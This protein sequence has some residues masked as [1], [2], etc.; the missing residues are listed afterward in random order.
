M[1]HR[2]TRAAALA[3]ATLTLSACS[4]VNLDVLSFGGAKEQDTSRPP[5]GATA[6]Q[7]EGGKRLFV[8]YLDNGAAAWVILP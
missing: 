5:A 2:I 1:K 8:R 3:C 6:Y 7:C 4:S